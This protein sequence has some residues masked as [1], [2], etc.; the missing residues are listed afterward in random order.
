M[1][2]RLLWTSAGFSRVPPVFNKAAVVSYADYGIYVKLVEKLKRTVELH[3]PGLD[4]LIFR[5]PEEIGAPSHQNNPYAFKVYSIQKARDLGYT[6]ILWCDSVLRPVRS[7]VPLIEDINKIGI[8][9]QKDGY[10]CGQWA[11]D[12]ALEYF[13]VTRDEA[14]NISSIYAC[15]MG[16]NFKSELACE[17]FRRWKRACDDGIF[18][19]R[20]KNDEKT[21]SQDERCHGHRH[22]QT[23]SELIAYQIGIP[24]NAQ[25]FS[26]DTKFPN[27]YF[28]GWDKP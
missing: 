25:V 24:L 9:F 8:Y 1:A 27:R 26:Y 6:T 5:S 12:R 13:K 17:Y 15:F 14:M 23:S 19:G 10:M 11:N 2:S 22:D 20:W 4:V 21:E 28:T 7:L 16:F 3:N 18:R